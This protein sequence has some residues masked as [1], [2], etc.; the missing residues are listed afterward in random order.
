VRSTFA[1]RNNVVEMH[2]VEGNED[3]IANELNA[4]V[5]FVTTPNYSTIDLLNRTI[6]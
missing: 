3:T 6:A 1:N 2:L 4:T 5:T